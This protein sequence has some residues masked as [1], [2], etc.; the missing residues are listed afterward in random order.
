MQKKNIGLFYMSNIFRIVLLTHTYGIEF[1]W[2]QTNV[3]TSEKAKYN[4]SLIG[5]KRVESTKEKWHFCREQ[6]YKMCQKKN[7]CAGHVSNAYIYQMVRK[8]K[9]S[10]G[11]V[12]QI[13]PWKTE[14]FP[15]AGDEM[16]TTAAPYKRNVI[17]VGFN[18]ANEAFGFVLAHATNMLTYIDVICG[19]PGQ[20]LLKSFID[21][22]GKRRIRLSSLLHVMGYYPKFGF[23]FGKCGEY[24]ELTK[25]IQEF[26]LHAF[27]DHTQVPKDA[28]KLITYLRKKDL[29]T[30]VAPASDEKYCKKLSTDKFL[31][32][33]CIDNGVKME[34]CQPKKFEVRNPLRSD[35]TLRSDRVIAT[36]TR[37]KTPR[38]S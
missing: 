7:P 31:E 27:A 37:S 30:A 4:Y 1:E 2:Q 33:N 12:P 28:Q 5:N 16:A 8:Q 9:L 18:E 3:G 25:K 11:V 13:A 20:I 26:P 36:R 6:V 32:E 23:E 34:R 24:P 19:N 38:K 22:S 14:K 15:K 17:M 10:S 35:R 21:W 29:I